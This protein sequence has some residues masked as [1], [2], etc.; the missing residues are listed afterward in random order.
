MTTKATIRRRWAPLFTWPALVLG[1][2]AWSISPAETE[3]SGSIDLEV[4]GFAHA[5]SH[6]GQRRNT[7]SVAFQPEIYIPWGDEQ[8]SVLISPFLR[9]DSSD[10]RRTHADLREAI[11][12]YV[13]RGWE[14]RAGLGRVFWGVTESRHLVDIIN[15]TDAI[16][17]INGEDKLGQPMITASVS[18]RW[19]TVDAFVLPYFRERTFPGRNARLRSEPRVESSLAR[20][21]SSAKRRRIDWALRY[22]HA[23]GDWDIGLSHFHGTSRDPRLL[24]ARLSTGEIVLV[25]QY[26][27]I[28]QTGLDL[29]A[30]KGNWLWKLE[31]IHTSG[32][33]PTFNAVVAGLEYTFVGIA[34]SAADLGVL[35]ELLYDD[36]GNSAPHPFERDIFVG[37]R[38]ALNDVA[39]SELLAGF[40]HDLGGSAAAFSVEASRRLGDEWKLGVEL[41][42]WGKVRPADPQFTLR[43]DDHV[44]FTLQRFF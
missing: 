8:H 22:S 32:Q 25:P 34:D 35:T 36:R 30:T 2:T 26:D 31:A 18:R 12:Q 5:P 7:G 17:N 15:Q 3:M 6:P 37:A 42:A 40:I 16:E 27:A 33:G 29:Q 24:P 20:F 44:Q 13:G 14:L 9:I 19:G 23:L 1:M 21:E 4:R 10:A 38:L 28:H 39:S 43:R 41:R 11:Y